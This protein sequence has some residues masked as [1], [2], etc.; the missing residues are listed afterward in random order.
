MS[1]ESGFQL[2]VDSPT[3]L[4]ELLLE[5]LFEVLFELRGVLLLVVA[6]GR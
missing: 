6:H 2:L 5:V 1:F 4:V 3:V